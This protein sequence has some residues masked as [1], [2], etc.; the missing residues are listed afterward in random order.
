MGAIAYLR[1]SYISEEYE[2]RMQLDIINKVCDADAIA[3]SVSNMYRL[4]LTPFDLSVRY[5]AW[6]EV[7]EA[8]SQTP[9]F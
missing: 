2:M 4:V 7:Y 5:N 6:I 3:G 8:I 1:Q 9:I